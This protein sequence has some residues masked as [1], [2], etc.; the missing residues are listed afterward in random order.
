[1]VGRD[2]ALRALRGKVAGREFEYA[3][4]LEVSDGGSAGFMLRVRAGQRLHPHTLILA[5]DE[6]S[7]TLE[8]S[9]GEPLETDDAETW[10]DGV[11]YW[12]MEELDTGVLRR[13]GR[14]TLDDG[15][16][17]V[18]PSLE[19]DAS[20]QPWYVSEVPLDRPTRAGQ[21]RLLWTALRARRRSFVTIGDHVPH[22]PDPT[23][24]GYLREAGFEVGPGR[25][26]HADGRLIQWLQLFR[27]DRHAS[28]PLGQLVVSW[29]DEPEGVAQ[30]EHLECKP[31]APHA[32]VEQLMLAGVHDAADAGARWIEHRLDHA[33]DL[34]L[35]LPWQTADGV[36]RLSAADVP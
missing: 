33:D 1:V 23:P 35:G 36:M 3:T 20:H 24:G 7:L 21:R 32:A 29:R 31:Q 19:T 11:Y 14:V 8:H 18:D 17:A 16:V 30:L 10:A 6:K 26:A 13:G 9:I 28:L 15:T 34:D 5:V 12:L 4:V 2:E 25:A 27:D 22:E